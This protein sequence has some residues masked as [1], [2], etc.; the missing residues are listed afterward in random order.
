LRLGIKER[1]MAALDLDLIFQPVTPDRWPDLERLFG[2]RGAYAGCWCMFWRLRRSEFDRFSAEER[3]TGLKGLVDSG[4]IPGILAYQGDEP[5]AWV[6][7]G[8]RETFPPLEHSRTLV[9]VDAQPVWSIVCF[10]VA[11]AYR[12]Q[13]LMVKLLA[14]AVAYAASQ[15]AQI[16][17]GYPV[18]PPEGQ[19]VSGGS[20][21]YMGLASTFRKAGFVEVARPSE[22]RAIMRYTCPA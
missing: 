6:S 20:E 16:V 11:K 12:R 19:R 13:G 10:F 9:R 1:L 3:R 21:G 18:D 5:I 22:R 2:P 15:G 4:Q 7:L 8:P 14:G 17:E